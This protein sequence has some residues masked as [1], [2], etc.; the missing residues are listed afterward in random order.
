MNAYKIVYHDRDT[1]WEKV[2]IITMGEESTYHVMELFDDN[3]NYDVLCV[4]SETLMHK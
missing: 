1:P 2:E 3:I 4:N